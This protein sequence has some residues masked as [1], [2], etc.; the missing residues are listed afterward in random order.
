MQIYLSE[1]AENLFIDS[2]EHY[3]M[4]DTDLIRRTDLGG[5]VTELA[6]NRPEKLNAFDAALRARPSGIL[7]API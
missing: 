4:T 3:H 1:P 7:R 2:K 5:H 6:L